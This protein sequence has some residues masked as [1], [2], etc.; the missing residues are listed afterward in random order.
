MQSQSIRWSSSSKLGGF[1]VVIV[2]VISNYHMVL[3]H[4]YVRALTNPVWNGF[5]G[6]KCDPCFPEVER[7]TG[8]R[9]SQG[10]HA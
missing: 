3:V 5:E 1:H 10:R 4:N 8:H 7:L 2:L 6:C 9:V